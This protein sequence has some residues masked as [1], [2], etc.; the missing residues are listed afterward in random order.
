MAE[1]QAA[2]MA[3]RSL[4]KTLDETYERIFQR[5]RDEDYT[6]V[7]TALALICGKSRATGTPLITTVLLRLLNPLPANQWGE[8]TYQGLTLSHLRRVSGC[9]LTVSVHKNDEMG[10]IE[11]AHY[12]VKEFLLSDRIAQG[13]ASQFSLSEVYARREYCRRVLLVVSELQ[14]WETEHAPY[15]CGPGYFCANEVLGGLLRE[16][17]GD[18]LQDQQLKDLYRIVLDPSRPSWDFLGSIHKFSDYYFHLIP[19]SEPPDCPDAAAFANFVSVELFFLA[20]ELVQTLDIDKILYRTPISTRGLSN[21]VRTSSIVDFYNEWPE[22]CY[23]NNRE[24]HYGC[25]KQILKI[26]A[27][28][29]DPTAALCTYLGY[30]EHY[31]PP[32]SVGHCMAHEFFACGA[33]VN[34]VGYRVTPLQI[35]TYR[36]DA[37]AVTDLLDWGASVTGV[38]DPAGVAVLG[39]RFDVIPADMPPLT[40]VRSLRSLGVDVDSAESLQAVQLVEEVLLKRSTKEDGVDEDQEGGCDSEVAIGRIGEKS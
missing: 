38:G 6:L 34:G 15:L 8:T 1:T 25:N 3:I 21:L 36:L 22:A 16:C 18:A 28:A 26:A 17:E 14:N 11:L 12:I 39:G 31:D 30:H 5:I 4:P 37:S 20:K 2:K 10:V 9:L 33:D 7:Q 29:G 24:T 35:A 40:L 27:G 32:G 19:Y 13:P 23:V